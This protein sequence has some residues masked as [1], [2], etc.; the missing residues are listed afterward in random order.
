MTERGANSSFTSPSIA[1]RLLLQR[2]GL[3]LG[4]IALASLLN[5]DLQAA[6]SSAIASPHLAPRAKHVIYLHMVGA[7]SHLDLLEYKP[8]LTKFHGQ[9][10]PDELLAK[11]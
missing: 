3:G 8:A 2:G 4:S 9:P 5:R 7:P 6:A 10:C 11:S 1:R